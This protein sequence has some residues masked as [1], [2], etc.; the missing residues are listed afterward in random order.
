MASSGFDPRGRASESALFLNRERQLHRIANSVALLGT[1]PSHFRVF[2]VVGYG[3]VGKSKLLKQLR[4]QSAELPGSNAIS[5]VELLQQGATTEVGPLLKIRSDVRYDCLLFDTA[6]MYYWAATGQKF[7]TEH[8]NR[9][10]ESIPFKLLDIGRGAVGAPIPLPTALDIIAAAVRKANKR[11]YYEKEEFEVLWELRD[12]ARALHAALPRCLGTD[13]RRYLEEDGRA[14]VA[15]YDD[16]DRQAPKTL[17]ENAAWLREFIETLGRGVHVIA[18]RERL[19]WEGAPWREVLELV[20]VDKLPVEQCR[21]MVGARLGPVPREIE[22][23]IIRTAERVPFYLETIIAAYKK[24]AGEQRTISVSD[25]PSS[26]D[27]AVERLIEHLPDDQR[28]LAVALAAV[29]MFDRELFECVIRDLHLKPD[30]TEFERFIGWFFVSEVNSPLYKVHDL[31]SAFVRGS[32]RH[33]SIAGLAL[34]AATKNLDLRAAHGRLADCATTLQLFRAVGAGWFAQARMPEESVETFIDAGYRLYDAGYWNELASMLPPIAPGATHPMAGIVEFF[35]ALSARRTADV[36][37]ALELFEP[38]ESRRSLGRHA[39]SVELEVA[40]LSELAGNYAR[41]RHQFEQLERAAQPFNATDRTHL[42]ARLYHADMLIM[43]GAL[44]EGSRLLLE[45]SDEIGPLLPLDWAELVRH[46]GHAFRFSLLLDSAEQRYVEALHVV[47]NARA[48]VGK[49]QTNLVETLC[50]ADPQRALDAALLSTLYNE[51]LGNEIELAKCNAAKAI[52]L[53]G[54]G[55]FAAARDA[56][57]TAT[58]Q[59]RRVGYPAGEAF[60]LQAAAVVEGRDG[61]LDGVRSRREA[62]SRAVQMLD[63][64]SHLLLIPAWLT[65]DD[66]LIATAIGDA[67]WLE[68]EELEVRLR[69]LFGAAGLL[70]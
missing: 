34:A 15:F 11:L 29:Q 68:P 40:Y 28:P 41:A 56:V 45:A 3:G 35:A 63:T 18:S 36:D 54:L 38:L 39:R 23:H 51:G 21:E 2:E 10:K 30:F 25:L 49:L 14:F 58:Q 33:G 52:A 8:R 16:Y 62:L 65:G 53:A 22:D 66:A 19:R 37:R 6:V 59:S 50:W 42:R 13:I 46:R 7:S 43:D 57:E 70:R 20:P 9:L 24:L 69:R 4:K 31:L 12:D 44:K 32:S 64:Y 17:A 48:I 60:A 47:T 55:E 27:V 26:A 5:H 1:V 61:N 67:T